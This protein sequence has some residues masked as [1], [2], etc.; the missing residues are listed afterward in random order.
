MHL[1][2][3]LCVFVVL[4]QEKVIQPASGIPPDQL[5]QL[6]RVIR[7]KHQLRDNHLHVKIHCHPVTPHARCEPEFRLIKAGAFERFGY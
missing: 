3:H 2:M 1:P 7:I 4:H 5:C 6:L